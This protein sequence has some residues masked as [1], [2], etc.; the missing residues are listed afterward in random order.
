MNRLSF[1]KT[2]PVRKINITLFC[3]YEAQ[4]YH[5][6]YKLWKQ[7]QTCEKKRSLPKVSDSGYQQNYRKLIFEK[8]K[9]AC[10]IV[11]LKTKPFKFI[12]SN[13]KKLA[14]QTETPVWPIKNITVKSPAS[15]NFN[16]LVPAVQEEDFNQTRKPLKVER[17]GSLLRPLNSGQ[18]SITRLKGVFTAEVIVLWKFCSKEVDNLEQGRPLTVTIA[19]C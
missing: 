7:L 14:I 15:W 11:L 2:F 1:R 16:F 13:A 5:F 8:R 3:L 18:P 4:K 19:T 10:L 17:I 6:F 12:D 9:T